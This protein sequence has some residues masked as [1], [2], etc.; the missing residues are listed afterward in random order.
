MAMIERAKTYTSPDGTLTFTVEVEREGTTILS[1]GYP[2]HTHPDLLITELDRSEEAAI[3]SFV[4]ELLNNQTVIAISRRAGRIA[5]IGIT[6]DPAAEL[7]NA[8]DGEIVELRYWN[9]SPWRN[10]SA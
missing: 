1:F 7:R 10:P 6:L 4:G 3:E 9:G 2:W 8:L 5:D